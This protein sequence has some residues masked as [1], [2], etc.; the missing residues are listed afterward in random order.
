MNWSVEAQ[1]WENI[2]VQGRSRILAKR[3]NYDDAA[4]L[5]LWCCF[6]GKVSNPDHL[7]R[8]LQARWDKANPDTPLPTAI[9]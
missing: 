8:Q 6:N 1:V 5:I 9:F 2:L 4:L 7:L 3:T